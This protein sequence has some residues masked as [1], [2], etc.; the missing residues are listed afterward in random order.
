MYSIVYRYE[1]SFVWSV[2]LVVD[3]VVSVVK[4]CAV[5]DDIV[6]NNTTYNISI[7]RKISLII[8]VGY[9]I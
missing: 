2:S 5:E 3:H 4:H 9:N 6:Y 1:Y 8:D 7:D